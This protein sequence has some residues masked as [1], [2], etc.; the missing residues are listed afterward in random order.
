M[1]MY[2]CMYV[3][4][5][6]YMNICI[7]TTSRHYTHTSNTHPN[8]QTTQTHARDCYDQFSTVYVLH[9]FFRSWGISVCCI[10]FVFVCCISVCCI[11]VC[12]IS[13]CCISVVFVCCIYFPDP[14]A[15][16]Y[17][18]HTCPEHTCWMVYDVYCIHIYTYWVYL[19][20]GIFTHISLHCWAV[21]WLNA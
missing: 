14:G 10:S 13:V 7:V 9:V 19:I 6:I 2:V 17:C 16:N 8:Q 12:S 5:Y 11:S 20:L 15:S 18:T 21:L 3:Y 4:I 1:C